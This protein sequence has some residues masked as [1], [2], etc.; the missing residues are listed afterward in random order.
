VAPA[1][2]QAK[3]LLKESKREDILKVM[4]ALNGKLSSVYNQKKSLVPLAFKL[5]KGL[6]KK[7]SSA[8][9]EKPAPS[10]QALEAPTSVTQQEPSEESASKPPATSERS[11]IQEAKTPIAR[12]EQFKKEV[13]PEA[14]PTVAKAQPKTS[15]SLGQFGQKIQR[16]HVQEIPKQ[17]HNS[18]SLPPWVVGP[19]PTTEAPS[20]E[21]RILGLE[22]LLVMAQQLPS[23]RVDARSVS[24]ALERALYQWA[25]SPRARTEDGSSKPGK[26]PWV[27]PYWER[28]HAIVAGVCGKKDSVGTLANLVVSG[29]YATPTKL[30]E[31]AD[32]DFAKSFNGQPLL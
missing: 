14:A 8:T 20:E 23:D 9:A 6:A 26:A 4:K 28:L 27:R 11:S 24:V 31:L 22:F 5:P 30:V 2:K 15:F 3:A 32:D 12:K 10:K 13:P 19:V 16:D 1:V 25:T 17:G 18:Q 21:D 7:P 29:H